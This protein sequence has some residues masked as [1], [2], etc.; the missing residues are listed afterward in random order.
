MTCERK[1]LFTQ[2]FRISFLPRSRKLKQNLQPATL[3]LIDGHVHIVGNGSG[4]TGCWLHITGW[5]RP[6][7]ALMVH[8]IGL[9]QS[10][11]K[12]DLD[13]LYVDALL[14]QLRASSVRYAVILAQ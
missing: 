14:A 9:P 6:L 3:N 11:L 7:A 13:R 1:Y 5:H 10:S 12:G 8:G 4:G 2:E